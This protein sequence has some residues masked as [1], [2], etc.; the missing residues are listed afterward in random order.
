MV[1]RCGVGALHLQRGVLGHQKNVGNV[2]T[3]LLVEVTPLL[4]QFHGLSGGD[5]LEIDDGVGYAA[6][7]ADDQALEAN[8]FLAVGVANLRILGNREIQFAGHRSRPFDGP[9]DGA[10][11]GDGNHPIVTLRGGEGCD[12]KK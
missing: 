7:G 10:T 3:L 6:L 12:R 8:R 11:V 5:V 9:G 2:V 4:G 1:C